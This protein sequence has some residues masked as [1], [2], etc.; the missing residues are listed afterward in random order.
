MNRKHVRRYPAWIE[1]VWL[2]LTREHLLVPSDRDALHSIQKDVAALSDLFTTARTCNFSNYASDPRRLLAYGLFFFPQTYMRTRAVLH[3]VMPF[4]AAPRTRLRVLDLGA[5]SGA[6]SF[7]LADCSIDQDLD[8]T[9]IDISA[10]AL[11]L[12]REI[13]RRAGTQF[14]GT[15]KT[16]VGGMDSQQTADGSFD[17]ILCSFALNELL[18]GDENPARGQRWIDAC[19][20]LLNDGGLL[21]VLE[22]A[23]HAACDRLVA[24]R[25]AIAAQGRVEILAPCLHPLPFPMRGRDGVWCHDIRTWTVPSSVEYLNRR[26]LRGVPYLKYALLCLRKRLPVVRPPDPARCRLVGPMTSQKG[27]YTVFGC[28]ADG[29]IRTFEIL[30]R[31]LDKNTWRRFDEFERGDCL[32]WTDLKPIADGKTWRGNAIIEESVIT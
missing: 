21:V 30:T 28:A 26:L 4:L 17:I 11:S 14:R 23:L 16:C 24:L 29:H 7:A 12:M 6:A 5:G 22:P 19:M 20:A 31:H 13:R 25:D 9:A 1:Q 8:I 15:L 32:R 27:R 18:E 2:D 10:G 3:E